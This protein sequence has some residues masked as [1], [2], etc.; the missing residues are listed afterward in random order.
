MANQEKTPK[1]RHNNPFKRLYRYPLVFIGETFDW[2]LTGR[3]MLYSALIGVVGAFGALLFA[4]ITDL[5]THLAIEEWIGYF[6]PRPGGEGGAVLSE[7]TQPLRPW[8]LFLVP[9]IGGLIAGWL[10]FTFAPEAEGHGT[11]AVIRAFHQRG[12]Y[13]RPL[14]PVIKTIASAITL[15]TGG[16]A[17]REGPIAQI[18][19]GFASWVSTKMRLS[20]RERRIFVLAGVAA[21]VGSIFRA[22]LGGAFFAVEVLYR[23]DIETEALMPSVV[24]SITGYS[25]YSS[26]KGTGTLF[27]TPSFHAL[28]PFELLPLVGF[29]LLCVLV[30]ALYT[31]VFYGTKEQLFDQLPIPLHFRPAIGGF[32]L[33]V[34]AFFF[35]QVLGTSYGW[36]QLA[37]DGQL[38]VYVMAAISLLKIFATSFTISSGGSGG[39]FGPSL[40]IGGMLGGAYGQLMHEQL[41]DL[42]SQPGAYVIIGMGTLFAG[43]AK[44]PLTVTI[45]LSELTGSY[46]LLIPLILSSTI[47]SLASRRWSLYREQVRNRAES[48]AHRLEMTPELLQQIKVKNVI[49]YPVYFHTVSPEHTLDEI[50][51]VFTRTREE[52]LPVEQETPEGKKYVGLVLLSDLQSLLRASPELRRALIAQDVAVPFRAVR[53]DDTLEHVLK[54]FEETGYPQ[55]PVVDDKG[56]IVGFISLEQLISEYHR[57]YLRKKQEQETL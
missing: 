9:T 11:D 26:I 49:K 25:I 46:T 51:D 15:G 35:P 20:E 19:A 1:R 34:L 10:V 28:H 53:L 40:V 41:P 42:F 12:G 39:V 18:G 48:P 23:E 17:G 7:L 5:I 27:T 24:A 50:L 21:G 31:Q 45:M 54:V 22:P 56:E 33:G 3:W 8:L 36:L 38:P 13:I 30:G 2:K 43:V 29:A 47:A 14:V 32:L 4:E 52:V 55:L 57:A 6:V 16:S 37:I 44:V